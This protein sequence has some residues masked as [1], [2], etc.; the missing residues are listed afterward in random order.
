MNGPLNFN[1]RNPLRRLHQWYFQ[2]YFQT[3][4]R[5]AG[6]LLISSILIFI[7]PI[8]PPVQ[9]WNSKA[10]KNS[11]FEWPSS[12]GPLQTILPML[13]SL[14]NFSQTQQHPKLLLLYWKGKPKQKEKKVLRKKLRINQKVWKKFWKKKIWG[15]K[16]FIKFLRKYSENKFEN[17]YWRRKKLKKKK[18][19]K[20]KIW[21][22]FIKER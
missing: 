3:S 15:K 7:L 13:S 17:L 1:K 11:A 9:D 4:L 2:K 16:S 19:Y 22:I 21:E 14:R 8:P 6:V 18:I 20:N 10:W 5:G 12:G